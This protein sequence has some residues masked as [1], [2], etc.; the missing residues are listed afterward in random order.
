[1]LEMW[2]FMVKY[3]YVN[4]INYEKDFIFNGNIANVIYRMFI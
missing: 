2:S 1:M 4:N 3:K